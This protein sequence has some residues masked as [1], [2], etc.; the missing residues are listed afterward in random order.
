MILFNIVCR[1]KF[2][3][4]DVEELLETT[5]RVMMRVTSLKQW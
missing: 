3:I 2:K 5:L 4:K 1:V